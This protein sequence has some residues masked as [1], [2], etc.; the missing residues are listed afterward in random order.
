MEALAAFAS[1]DA[2]P[3]PMTLV[4]V[5]PACSRLKVLN[6][7]KSVHGF[8]LRSFRGHG[9]NLILDNAILEM[10]A[11]CGDLV[12]ARH[13]FG[14]M[15]ERDVVSWTTLIA[16]Y[17][18]NQ[19]SE[20]A[21]VVFS[22]MLWDGEAAPNELTLMSVLRACA[23]V[24]ALRLGKCLHSCLLKNCT[25]VDEL[26]GNALVNFYAK[27]GDVGT[28][29]KVFTGISCKDLVSW[30]TMIWGMAMNG[31]GKQAL[32]LFASMLCHGV[33]PDGLAF[34]AVLSACCH[35]GLVD[36]GLM[37]FRA[38]I[39][40]YGIVPQKEHYTCMVDA[41]GRAGKVEEAESLVKGMPAEIDGHVWGALL[42]SCRLHGGG[43]VESEC[44]SGQVLEGDVSFG[45]GMYAL[46][47]NMLASGG[48]WENSHSVREQMRARRIRK[49]VGCSWIE[50][51]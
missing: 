27:C 28:S 31:R 32:Q 39:E 4:S 49:I 25:G 40:V 43:K 29:C 33:R 22:A 13:L 47:S 14:E 34:L 42:S 3:N 8:G 24:G 35:A 12:S 18:R 38:M 23:S 30:C 51:H 7:G 17:A 50:V 48:R 36:E 16:G 41:Y 46:V 9:S 5:L 1:M 21:I 20:E 15:A 45:G 19:S 2:R 11:S 44:L 6:P 10:Y 37:I 26:V